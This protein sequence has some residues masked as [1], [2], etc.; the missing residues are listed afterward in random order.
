MEDGNLTDVINLKT[1]THSYHIRFTSFGNAGSKPLIFIH[2]TPW[3]SKVWVPLA[4]AFA[5]SF[6]VY[7]FD[8]PGYG[9]SPGG[10]PISSSG[11]ELDV[12]LAGQA[13]AFAKLVEAWKLPGPP[14]VI[15]HDIGGLI[16]LRANLCHGVEYAS[17]CLVDAV[18]VTPFGS[19]FFRLV[20]GNSDVFNMI[21]D[22]LMEGLIR[23]Y[24]Q[25]AAFKRLGQ[26]VEDMLAGPWL[27]TGLQR[28][29][30]FIRQMKQADNRHVEDVEPR[31]H[32]VGERIPV[33]IIWGKE[34][35]WIPVD[36]AAK[37]GKMIGTDEVVIVAGAGHLIHFDQPVRLAVELSSWLARVA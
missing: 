4:R 23:A 17:L 11:K 5:E 30:G 15:A 24:I 6:H 18:A 3:S 33:K 32:E 26:E 27:A 29:A 10:T 34:D 28:K 7:L 37:L 14:H 31:Y 19:P 25:G 21:P 13:E 9:E 1:D 16:S 22:G 20:A 36:R 2:G 35:A 12:S 8:N